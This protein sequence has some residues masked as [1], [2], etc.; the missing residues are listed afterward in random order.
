MPFCPRLSRLLGNHLHLCPRCLQ[1]K[2]FVVVSTPIVPVV[3][4]YFKSVLDRPAHHPSRTHRTD[5]SRR[6]RRETIARRPGATIRPT[7]STIRCRPTNRSAGHPPAPPEAMPR[8]SAGVPARDGS[9]GLSDSIT[10]LRTALL[11]FGGDGPGATA[12]TLILCLA[13]VR[14]HFGEHLYAAL[15]RVVR[16]VPSQAFGCR[17][18]RVHDHS[19]TP[20]STASWAASLGAETRP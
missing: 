6:R 7:D 18:R 3:A 15:R 13:E 20:R 8:R 4:V 19:S 2:I 1:Q 12:F 14:L 17:R 9:P 10:R 5:W 11:D 16:V